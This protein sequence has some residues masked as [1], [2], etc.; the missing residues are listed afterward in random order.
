MQNFTKLR[1]WQSAMEFY[2]EV[3][4]ET[5]SFPSE[6]RY[7]LTSQ[8]RRAARSVAGNIAEGAGCRGD[9]DTVHFYHIG[10][11]SSSEC[12]SDMYLAQA[13]GLLAQEGFD[14]LESKIL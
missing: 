7:G 13:V 3:Y 1:A 6:E 12:Y 2:V 4:N 11:A 9:R 5:K 8:M 10:F 14:R